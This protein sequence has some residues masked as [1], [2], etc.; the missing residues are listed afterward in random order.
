MKNIKELS[1]TVGAC[2]RTALKQLWKWKWQIITVVLL[3]VIPIPAYIMM[4]EFVYPVS[5]QRSELIYYF[6]LLFVYIIE[7]VLLLITWSPRFSATFTVLFCGLVGFAECLVMDF[8]S[9]PIMPWDLLSFGTAMSVVGDYKFEFTRKIIL[10][11]VGFVLLIASALFLCRARIKPKARIGTKI[12]ARLL[13]VLL[14][15]PMLF[16]YA[17]VAQSENFQNKA[18]YYPYLFTPNAVYKYNGFYFSFIS[19]LKYMNV[20]EPGGYDAKKLEEAVAFIEPYE[21]PDLPNVENPN[22]IIIM[23]E[24]FSDLSVLGDYGYEKDCMPFINSLTEN[25][26]KGQAYVSV[27]GGNTPNSEWEFLTGNTMAF[28][29]S[30]SI[31]Y[32][33]Y[34]RSETENLM[35]TL[36]EKGY[37]TYGIHP[38]NAGGWKRNTVYPLLGIDNMLFNTDFGGAERIRSYIS[39]EAVYDK[40]IRIYHENL[41]NDSPL[42]FFC[43]TMQNHGGYSNFREYEQFAFLEEEM[44]NM[45][46]KLANKLTISGYMSLIQM[47]DAA[48]GKLIEFFEGEDEPT[49]I[50][51]FGDH[52]PNST[53]TKPILNLMGIEEDT[54]DWSVRSNQYIVPFVL[55][56]N[57]DIEEQDGIVTSLNYLNI[58]LSEN[59][60]FELSGY[61]T[62]RKRL[63]EKYPV[64]TANFCI[65]SR[66]ELFSWDE[67]D[68][69]DDEDLL[70]Y[71]QLQYN[72]S[73]DTKHTI[74]DFFD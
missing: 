64:I 33:Q 9:Q 45:P 3:L 4:E 67:L 49:I 38:Y 46:S 6:N 62:F 47:S 74:E 25:T 69:E 8:R 57:Y 37:V 34:M 53:V 21:E 35:T 14:C 58:L 54:E 36:K 43:V 18:G 11:I 56:A 10:L 60:G 17:S 51:M 27:K 40:I 28:L 72:H 20:D 65:N 48:L 70:L 2:L 30:G 44:D 32:Q 16:G 1:H 23:N 29:P 26:V 31:P 12:A 13:C 55:W 68:P 66:G 59:A 19:L 52:Q 63:S 50:L 42:A 7:A 41:A 24:S 15:V 5:G 71:K 22:V 61:Q 39:D 73:F